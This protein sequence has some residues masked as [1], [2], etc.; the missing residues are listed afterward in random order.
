MHPQATA[1]QASSSGERDMAFLP[2]ICAD[3]GLLACPHT[4]CFL[5]LFSGARVVTCLIPERGGTRGPQI[6]RVRPWRTVRS[7]TRCSDVVLDACK[8]QNNNTGK[9]QCSCFA[10]GKRGRCNISDTSELGKIEIFCANGCLSDVKKLK[11]EV[12]GL[13]AS[14]RKDE[15]VITSVIHQNWEK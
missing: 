9:R 12:C 4:P 13:A 8:R 7:L 11:S 6:C 14:A 2:A 10:Q 15:D 1:S 3:P 5:R